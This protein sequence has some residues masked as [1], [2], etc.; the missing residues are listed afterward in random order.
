MATLGDKIGG[1][2][3]NEIAMVGAHNAGSAMIRSGGPV[4]ESLG[5]GCFRCAELL[6]PGTAGGWMRTQDQGIEHQ[7]ESGVRFLDLQLLVGGDG[8]VY[9][10]APY[11]QG[12]LRTVLG[13]IRSFVE[14]HQREIVI[15][16]ISRLRN[17]SNRDYEAVARLVV[18]CLGERLARPDEAGA[19]VTPNALWARGQRIVVFYPEYGQRG[20]DDCPVCRRRVDTIEDAEYWL[21]D[22]LRQWLWVPDLL[23]SPDPKTTD[24]PEL[25]ERLE[26]SLGERHDERFLVLRGFIAPDTRMLAAGQ[27]ATT[28]RWFKEAE[29]HLSLCIPGFVRMAVPRFWRDC[30]PGALESCKSQPTSLEGLAESVTPRVAR[31]VERQWRAKPINIVLVDWFQRS[32]LVDVVIERNAT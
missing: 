22:A 18:D 28:G 31:W 1:R 16:S 24:I 2:P 20:G 13:I 11:E 4:D 30:F 19:R 23:D 12:N 9:V 15:V 6:A 26:Q 32:N 29:D 25:C 27:I 3:L 10:G 7:L 8:T 5:S 21:S 17:A 14:E